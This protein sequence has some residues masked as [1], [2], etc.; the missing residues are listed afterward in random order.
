MCFKKCFK[1]YFKSFLCSNLFF[2]SVL[3]DDLYRASLLPNSIWDKALS[4]D[5]QSRNDVNQVVVLR[6]SDV[7]D[8][9]SHIEL[10]FEAARNIDS[11]QEDVADE[12]IPSTYWEDNEDD[13]DDDEE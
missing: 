2:F 3:S 9:A 11:E 8:V 13:D 1:N 7:D 5:D 4:V 10:L 6:N 12:D